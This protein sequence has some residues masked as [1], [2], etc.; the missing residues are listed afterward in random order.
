MRILRHA[1]ITMTMEVYTK[2]SNKITRAAL[3]RL[4]D[5]LIGQEPEAEPTDR[6][7]ADDEDRPRAASTWHRAHPALIG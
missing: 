7:A 6:P 4:G 5:T 1:K 3:K 2:V